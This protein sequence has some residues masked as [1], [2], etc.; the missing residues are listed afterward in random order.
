MGA[1]DIDA[2]GVPGQVM[3]PT[4]LAKT[5]AEIRFAPARG[6]PANS[7]EHGRIERM[8]VRLRMTLLDPARDTLRNFWRAPRL[9]VLDTANGL[10]ES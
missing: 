4:D 10:R 6:R 8:K 2:S 3:H 5:R 1:N 9:H 7:D